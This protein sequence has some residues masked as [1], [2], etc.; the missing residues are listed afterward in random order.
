MMRTKN[1][2]QIST[3]TNIIDVTGKS[4]ITGITLALAV[5]KDTTRDSTITVGATY[6]YWR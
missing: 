5:A 3:V 1:K 4:D 2:R 6:R